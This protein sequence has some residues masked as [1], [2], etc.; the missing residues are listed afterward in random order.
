MLSARLIVSELTVV[1]VP[2]TIKLP[3]TV[4][5]SATVTIPVPFA[6][7]V[8][9]VSVLLDS[10]ASTSIWFENAIAFPSEDEIAFPAVICIGPFTSTCPVPVGLNSISPEPPV[11]IATFW[12]SSAETVIVPELSSTTF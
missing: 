2:E 1:V 7:S 11:D 9:L 6:L 12:L 3:V 10:I 4:N 5:A 8:K